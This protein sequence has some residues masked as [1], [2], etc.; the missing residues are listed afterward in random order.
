VARLL[1]GKDIF[2]AVAGRLIFE[3]VKG[4]V[5]LPFKIAKFVFDRLILMSR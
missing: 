2:N 3:I 1:L 5:I 4:I